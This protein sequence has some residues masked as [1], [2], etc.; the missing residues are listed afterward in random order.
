MFH[1]NDDGEEYVQVFRG[2]NGQVYYQYMS[3]GSGGRGR[4]SRN[5]QQ[6]Q[7]QRHQQQQW[8]SHWQFH[9]GFYEEPPL[10]Q[11]VIQMLFNLM[12]SMA[13]ILLFMCC[14]SLLDLAPRKPPLGR[15]LND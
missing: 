14:I 5:Q 15:R 11:Q 2:P 4:Q 7:Q 13:P 8:E 9:Q 3:G 12:S 10:W 1:D 6:Q